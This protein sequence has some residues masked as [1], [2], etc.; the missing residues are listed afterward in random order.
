MVQ[1]KKIY[2]KFLDV[3]Y[4]ESEILVLKCWIKICKFSRM[5]YYGDFLC[6]V[7]KDK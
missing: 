6:S 5:N 3:V 7:T 4:R 2:P 1:T